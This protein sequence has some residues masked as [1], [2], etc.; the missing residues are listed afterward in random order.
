MPEVIEDFFVAAGPI[1]GV[2]PKPVQ[3]DGHVYRVGKVPRTLQPIG[4]RLEPRFGRLG[5][6]YQKVVFDKALL[7]TDPTLEWVTPGHPLFEAVR[8]DVAERV[9]DDLQARRRLLRPPGEG[10]RAGSTSSPRRSRTA[11]ATPCTAASSSSRPTTPARSTV[12]QPTL[13]SPSWPSLRSARRSRA[14]AACP[15]A[16]ASSRPSSSRRCNPFLDGDRRPA[17]ARGRDHRPAPRDLPQRA[18]PSRQHVARRAARTAAS[19][20]RTSPASRATSPRP[21]RTSTS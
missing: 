13:S 16:R 18:D 2:H 10:A 9:R 5:R 12:R 20:A 8:D 11:A 1:A 15:T 4:E 7:P 17:R 19:R 6:E 21:R 3:K 14:T